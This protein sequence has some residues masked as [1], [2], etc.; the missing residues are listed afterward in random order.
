V[1]GSEKGRHFGA[2]MRKHVWRWTELLQRL[3]VTTTGAEQ[4]LKMWLSGISAEN[5][6]YQPHFSRNF[7]F[8][9]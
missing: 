4:V 9:R 8:A 6:R 5:V 2:E 3:E 1:G 7:G